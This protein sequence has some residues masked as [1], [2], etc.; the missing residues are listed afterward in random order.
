VVTTVTS[1]QATIKEEENS[2]LHPN[3]Q[4]QVLEVVAATLSSN[5][6]TLLFPGLI[7]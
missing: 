2:A 4:S 7:H 6:P 1:H 3:P 5:K